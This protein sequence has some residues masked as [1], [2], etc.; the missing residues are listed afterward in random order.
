MSIAKESLISCLSFYEDSNHAISAYR[1][2]A[3]RYVLHLMDSATSACGLHDVMCILDQQSVDTFKFVLQFTLDGLSQQELENELCSLASQMSFPLDLRV[4]VHTLNAITCY[5]TTALV[6]SRLKSNVHGFRDSYIFADALFEGEVLVNDRRCF[7]P[8][9]DTCA[10]TGTAETTVPE[11]VSLAEAMATELTEAEHIALVNLIPHTIDL[12][13]KRKKHHEA[14]LGWAHR[15]N[16]PT[17][18][19]KA[20]KDIEIE[21]AWL[22]ANV[23]QL[24]DLYLKIAPTLELP[25]IFKRATE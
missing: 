4:V 15:K 19:S 21:D 22:K 13:I 2:P 17:M 7:A 14:T 24:Q 11:S 12:H 1:I 3:L 18:C 25:N 23:A 16:I 8:V 5:F 20:R 6:W 10:D 9:V